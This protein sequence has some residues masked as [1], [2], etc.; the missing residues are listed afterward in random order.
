MAEFTTAATLAGEAVAYRVLVS[1]MEKPDVYQINVY[2]QLGIYT[3]TITFM[4]TPLVAVDPGESVGLAI[5]EAGPWQS[6][7]T[8][9]AHGEDLFHALV[10]L[11]SMYD[12]R[13]AEADVGT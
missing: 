3:A 6:G 9:T 13:Q 4:A 1:L 8:I 12:E 2:R 5:F 10:E 11:N 7:R